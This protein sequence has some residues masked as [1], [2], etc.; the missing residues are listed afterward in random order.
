MV[1]APDRSTTCKT[2]LCGWP[3]RSS[4]VLSLKPD[5][6]NNESIALPFAN[7][8]PI[9]MEDPKLVMW[10]TIRVDVAHKA[11]I[12]EHHDH[13]VR[14]LNNLHWFSGEDNPGHT[15]RKTAVHGIVRIL[16]W[17][18][19]AQIRVWRSGILPLPKESSVLLLAESKIEYVLA[20]GRVQYPNS[21]QISLRSGF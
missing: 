12:F 3:I 11:S 2:S 8:V 20:L 16:G 13:F 18:C 1:S 21:G 14:K 10:T 4:Q 17:F 15:R 6:I 9:H 5:Y 7:R 19:S